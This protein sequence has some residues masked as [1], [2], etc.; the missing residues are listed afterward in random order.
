MDITQ[1]EQNI[2]NIFNSFSDDEFIQTSNTF[3]E[4]ILYN[5]NNNDTISTIYSDDQH[6][7]QYT[8]DYFSENTESLKRYNKIFAKNH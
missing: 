8:E 5:D 3:T 7:N 2:K 1:I 4:D 6:I